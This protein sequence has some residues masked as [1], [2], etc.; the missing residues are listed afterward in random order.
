VNHNA[1]PAQSCFEIIC[2]VNVT[3]EAR[4][5]PHD[6]TCGALRCVL[7]YVNHQIELIA[8]DDTAARL[9]HVRKYPREVQ[10]IGFAKFFYLVLLLWHRFFL[11]RASAV[12]DVSPY[13]NARA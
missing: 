3:R 5:V 10:V 12:S 7:G 11:R 13:S 2:V 6:D 4:K 8:T 9:A 1:A